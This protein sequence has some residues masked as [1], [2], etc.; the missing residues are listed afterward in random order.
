MLGTICYEYTISKKEY[1]A[2]VGLAALGFGP[3]RTCCFKQVV[4]QVC[5]TD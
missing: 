5:K 4:C 2:S 1:T 3:C